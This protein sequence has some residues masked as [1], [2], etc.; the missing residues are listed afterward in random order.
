MLLSLDYAKCVDTI[1]PSLALRCLQFLGCP[2]QMPSSASIIWQ[3]MR[4]LCY[5]GEYLQEPSSVGTSI[6][7][8]DAI[9]PLSLLA[10]L[11]CLTARAVQEE[12]Q[13][14]HEHTVVTYLDDRN[15]VARTS[16]A[17]RG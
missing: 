16:R 14:G 9:S 10:L 1:D 3:Q 17:L 13:L 12:R 7:Q 2:P 8:G 6:P 15:L 4:W 11:I 5:K